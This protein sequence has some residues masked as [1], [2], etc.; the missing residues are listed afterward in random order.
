MNVAYESKLVD[1]VV[2]LGNAA[3]APNTK[4]EE[5]H[6]RK[7]KDLGRMF[8]FG[9][10]WK[11]VDFYTTSRDP[12]TQGIIEEVAAHGADFLLEHFS[13]ELHEILSAESEDGRHPIDIMGLIG[14]K[15]MLSVD[16][17]NSCHLDINDKSRSVAIWVE[18][19]PG[20]TENWYFILPHVSFRGSCGVVI[21]LFH[22][23][24]IS[25]DATVLYHCSTFSKNAQGG[26]A[27]G[28]MFGSCV[29]TNDAE[30]E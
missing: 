4:F 30:A 1:A 17:V 5:G 11:N 3:A 13:A 27:Y 25:W 15:I 24:A 22:G 28:C 8:G 2:K 23:C 7:W 26:H 19:I 16:L 21:K 14:S 12:D 10:N 29:G 18:S 20:S 9:Y 6:V